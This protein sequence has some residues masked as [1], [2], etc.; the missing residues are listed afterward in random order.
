MV[1]AVFFSSSFNV[2]EQ[3]QVYKHIQVKQQPRAKY[4]LHR[5]DFMKS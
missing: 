4:A 5:V 3:E 1:K 2:C